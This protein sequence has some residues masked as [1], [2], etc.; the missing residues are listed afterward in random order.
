[1]RRACLLILAVVGITGCGGSTRSSSSGTQSRP[2]AESS[3]SKSASTTTTTPNTALLAGLAYES[4]VN[5]MIKKDNRGITGQ[6]A[7]D[8]ATRVA[9]IEE[10]ITARRQLDSKVQ[11]MQF[12]V[13]VQSDV[14]A[15]LAADAS[16]EVAL[17]NLEVNVNVGNIPNFNAARYPSPTLATALHRVETD[18]GQFQSAATT[19][20][21]ALSSA[22]SASTTATP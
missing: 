13:S 2:S 8:P 20:D 18:Q 6:N 9:G 3:T 10:R 4:A 21:T 22:I 1:M 15:V 5:A 12:P 16:L 11:G 19:L 14:Q 17:G 7:S